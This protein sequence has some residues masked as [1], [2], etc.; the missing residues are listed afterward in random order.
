MSLLAR[1]WSYI[2]RYDI[3]PTF[4]KQNCNWDPMPLVYLAV[5]SA[6]PLCPGIVRVFIHRAKKKKCSGKVLCQTVILGHA[7]Q[8][9]N[10][11]SYSKLE[12][13]AH[14]WGWHDLFLLR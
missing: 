6:G 11:V 12:W 4:Q 3:S 2:S 13:S 8:A 14:R 1:M 5:R 9:L 10:S 7:G